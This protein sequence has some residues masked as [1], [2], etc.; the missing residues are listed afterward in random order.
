MIIVTIFFLQVI[1]RRFQ[2]LQRPS[3]SALYGRGIHSC[4]NSF[5]SPNIYRHDLGDSGISAAAL[6]SRTDDFRPVVPVPFEVTRLQRLAARGDVLDEELLSAAEKRYRTAK[7]EECRTEGDS[8]GVGKDGMG[9]D[10]VDPTGS[11]SRDKIETPVKRRGKRRR[12]E[13]NQDL[14]SCRKY[15]RVIQALGSESGW[16]CFDSQNKTL[17]LQLSTEEEKTRR[18]VELAEQLTERRFRSQHRS[19]PDVP[20]GTSSAPSTFPKGQLDGVDRNVPKISKTEFNDLTSC[21]DG[22]NCVLGIP[23]I[24]QG[25]A[26]LVVT[27]NNLVRTKVND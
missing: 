14:E 2:F 26:T 23:E 21:S 5:N 13:K 12:D 7:Q 20:I 4:P 24:L 25:R 10:G 17:E 18:S 6:A 11:Q 3:H 27:P 16:T 15:R 1:P 22:F 9:R 19:D 8:H